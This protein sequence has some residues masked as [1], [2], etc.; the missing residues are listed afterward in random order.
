[1]HG[2]RALRLDLREKLGIGFLVFLRKLPDLLLFRRIAVQC[3]D[4]RESAK[5]T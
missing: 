5:R 4:H 2:N 3:A 1:M